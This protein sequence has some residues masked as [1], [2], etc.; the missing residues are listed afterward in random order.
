MDANLNGGLF[1]NSSATT[2]PT[3]TVSSIKPRSRFCRPT[4]YGRVR[5]SG[6]NIDVYSFPGSS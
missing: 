1:I 6:V 3:T 2:A 5:N 4:L